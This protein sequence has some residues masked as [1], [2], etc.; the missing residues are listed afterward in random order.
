AAQA[1]AAPAE[2]APAPAQRSATVAAGVAI[3]T[4]PFWGWGVL[5]K[6][7]AEDVFAYLD[8]NTLFRLH[9]GGKGVPDAD[10]D[11]L[12][13]RESRPRLERLKRDVIARRI[14]QPRVIYGYY[15]CAAEGNQLVIF[16]P[17]D[18]A[19]RRELTRFDFPRQPDRE[20][21]CLADYFAPVE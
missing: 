8:L 10:W 13:A 4:P 6:I 5:D 2:P 12:V 17:A 15:P 14:I 19:A 3:P 18:P 16:D 11:A 7:P 1:E 9:W 20:H 21:L